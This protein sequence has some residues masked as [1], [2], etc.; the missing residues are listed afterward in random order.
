M[1]TKSGP[2]LVARSTSLDHPKCNL[3]AF[4]DSLAR[5]QT[6]HVL[7]PMLPSPDSSK[8]NA[9]AAPADCTQPA[10]KRACISAAAAARDRVAHAAYPQRTAPAACFHYT[11]SAPL[12]V[13]LDEAFLREACSRPTRQLSA[14]IEGNDHAKGTPFLLWLPSLPSTLCTSLGAPDGSTVCLAHRKHVSVR[15]TVLPSYVKKQLPSQLEH[16]ADVCGVIHPS[17][18][19]VLSLSAPAYARCG[20]QGTKATLRRSKGQA[21]SPLSADRYV[22]SVKLRGLHQRRKQLERAQ[23]AFARLPQALRWRLAAVEG[24]ESAVRATAE[25]SPPWISA[26][27]R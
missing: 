13:T 23:A 2:C 3:V 15:H 6:L 26:C 14:V 22:V 8:G 27:L 5:V 18:W 16:R 9:A 25:P 17:G 21:V 19:L 7:L 12:S 10:A 1:P 11:C 20:L 4:L 24:G